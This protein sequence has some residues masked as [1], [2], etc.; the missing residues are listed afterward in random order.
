M[1]GLSYPVI[2][3]PSEYHNTPEKLKVFIQGEIDN[4]IDCDRILLGFGLCG[5]AVLGLKA[6][7][8]DLIIPKADDCID[9]LLNTTVQ[10]K[11]RD[12]ATYFIS[13]GWLNNNGGILKE[14]EQ[15][16]NKYGESKA[17]CILKRLLVQYQYLMFIDTGL[18]DI[19]KQ[20]ESSKIMASK[21]ELEFILGKGSTYLLEKLLNGQLDD[22]FFIINKGDTVKFASAFNSWRNS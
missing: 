15:M 1:S 6:T 20:I 10:K 17:T 14:H 21:M 16:V 7:T 18:G 4:I 8:A 13:E 5:N 9:I 22:N 11:R 2:W 3:V 12:K 19:T